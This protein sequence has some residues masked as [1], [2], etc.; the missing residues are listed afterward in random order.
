MAIEARNRT[1]PDWM[2]RVR[3]GQTV[4]PR[5]QRRVAW[6]RG[7]VTDLFD[8]ILSDLPV[9][10]ALVL[11]VGDNEPFVS[12]ALKGA[13]KGTERVTEHLL[14][15][16]QRLTA[17][18]TGL[19]NTEDDVTYYLWLDP[20]D[21]SGRS[22][23]VW[24]EARWRRK[25][26]DKRYPA[27]LDEP[28]KLWEQS[29]VPLELCRPDHDLKAV[30][31]WAKVAIEENDE[32]DVFVDRMSA[33][34]Q[35]FSSFNLPFL[36]L[37]VTTPTDVALDVFTKMNTGGVP[38]ST[39]DILVA[40]VE[41][42]EGHSLQDLIAELRAAVPDIET[43]YNPDDLVLSA[44]ALLQGRGATNATY[45]STSFPA[46]LIEAW[47]RISVGADRA[48]AFLAEEG[49]LDKQRLPSE[50]VVPVIAALWADAPIS[51][52]AEGRARTL[53]RRYMWRAFFTRRYESSTN[54]R[55]LTDYLEL[56]AII[57]DPA[58][59]IPGIFDETHWPAPTLDEIISARWPKNKDRLARSLLA[60]AL[61]AGSLD[62]ADAS[63]VSRAS[64]AHRE[65]HHVFPD[66]YLAK[67]GR[68]PGEI[69]RALNCALVTWVTNRKMSAKPPLVYLSDRTKAAE[70]GEAEVRSRLTSHLIPYEPMAKDDYD[71][72]LKVRAGLMRAEM[73]RVAGFKVDLG[74]VVA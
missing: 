57:A 20:D 48:A 32:R 2:T 39:F 69:Y 8:T 62:F 42:A 16:Q 70:L 26:N 34:R 15:G 18:W 12:R 23:S 9:G 65:Y 41:A 68:T 35:K 55:A 58:A 22:V 17:L 50:V 4:L 25:G 3:T 19:H 6:D 47:P 21:D 27:W 56:K 73:D 54:S 44:A 64:L 33:I 49:I 11:E 67:Q 72:F 46:H 66:A 43:Y 28:D 61:R 38:L 5:F 7:R 59:P 52:D 63:P 45:L 53:I 24:S 14:D 31:D 1:L 40:Q 71:D 30:R 37:P 10:A 74:R 29:M 60:L 36:S 51:M 13:E